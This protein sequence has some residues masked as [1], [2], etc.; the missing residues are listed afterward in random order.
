MKLRKKRK[1][2]KNNKYDLIKTLLILVM[3]ICIIIAMITYW[4]YAYHHK[5]GSFYFDDTKIVSYK[6]SDY[7]E[8][9]GDILY[10]KNI[11]KDIIKDFTDKQENIINN[12]NILS[13]DITKGLYDNILSVMI[14]YTIYENTNNYEEIITINIDLKNNKVISNDELLNTVGSSYKKIATDIFNENIKLP[15]DLNKIVID[16]ITEKE[17]TTYE[18]NS[19]SEKYIIRIREK[20]PDVIKLYIEDNT[21]YSVVRLLE[22]DK[23]CYYTNI[24]R[25]INIKKEIGK[26]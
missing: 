3:L 26:I 20:L 5:Y 9:K 19:D 17:L 1:K 6:I 16:S 8:V 7:I 14:S 23:V 11:N 12:N 25:L 21:V 4:I 18:F 22:I 24:D 15:S 13:I 10:L 2:D